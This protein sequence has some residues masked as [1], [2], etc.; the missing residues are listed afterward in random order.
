MPGA[1]TSD[2]VSPTY[3]RGDGGLDYYDGVV[4]GADAIGRRATSPE[5][6]ER[7]AQLLTALEPDDYMSYVEAFLAR[8]DELVGPDHRFADITTVL[9]A[10]AEL[11]NPSSYLEIGVRRGRS[12]RVVAGVVPDCNIIGV[13]MWMP[14]YAG[15][16]NPGPE[17]VERELRSGGFTGDLQFVTGNSHKV[18]PQLFRQRSDLTFDLITVDGDHSNRGAAKDLRTVLPRLRVGGVLVFDDVRHPA[19]PG[20][21]RVWED[22]VVSDRRYSAWRYDDT[23][24]GVALAVRRW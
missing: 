17:H 24:Y 4:L 3:A 15:I 6:R 5:A 8:A 19:H 20:L 14:D 10:S 22:V 9:L 7:I 11:L 16:D 21:H 23:G 12:M 1:L 2:R 13:D 18:V